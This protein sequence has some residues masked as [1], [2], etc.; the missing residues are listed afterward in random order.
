[1]KKL[2]LRI[3]NAIYSK[4]KV[5]ASDSHWLAKPIEIKFMK[6][7]LYDTLETKTQNQN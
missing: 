6:F 4:K 2:S 5:L 1:M 3:W 7:H